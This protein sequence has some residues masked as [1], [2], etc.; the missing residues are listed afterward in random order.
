MKL[1]TIIP[2]YIS[3]FELEEARL[4]QVLQAIRLEDPDTAKIIENFGLLKKALLKI[5]DES[6]NAEYAIKHAGEVATSEI[7]KSISCVLNKLLK[8]D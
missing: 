5:K 7:E 8:K 1:Q 3:S 2:K 6:V 4:G